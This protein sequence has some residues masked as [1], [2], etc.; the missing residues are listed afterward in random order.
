[1]STVLLIN[2]KVSCNSCLQS[3]SQT[4]V[5]TYMTYIMEQ[6]SQQTS[7]VDIEEFR[8]LAVVFT[9][10]G[11][12]RPAEEPVHFTTEYGNPVDLAKILPGVQLQNTSSS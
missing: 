1:V 12:V 8:S 5:I 7:I 4:L 10:H 11:F 9:N 2:A 3:K 6:W